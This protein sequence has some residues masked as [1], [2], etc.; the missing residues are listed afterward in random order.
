M[1]DVQLWLSLSI[2]ID[3]FKSLLSFSVK[4]SSMIMQCL[5]IYGSYESMNLMNGCF[6]SYC[7]SVCQY[8][9]CLPFL[10]INTHQYQY[11][12][13]GGNPR[14][15]LRWS[16]PSWWTTP[17]SCNLVSPYHDN[18]GLSWTVS[19]PVK[20]IAVPVE[21]HGVLQTLICASVV[22]PKWCPTSSNPALLP[23]WMVVCPSFILLML[24]LLPGW[25]T[26]GVNRH[27]RKKKKKKCQYK[28]EV[29]KR[30]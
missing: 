23:S 1:Y 18:S 6:L 26:M 19:A 11:G 16:M 5:W 24:L 8:L 13:N 3:L 14:S 9:K 7:K 10:N 17:Q 22:R 29:I 27:I 4:L 20:G 15:R 25:P 21:R 28:L 30:V 2:D 12:I